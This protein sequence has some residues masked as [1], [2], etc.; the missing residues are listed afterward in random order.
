MITEGFALLLSETLV[1]LA[2]A[3]HSV[4]PCGAAGLEISRLTRLRLLTP[5][6]SHTRDLSDIRARAR[7]RQRRGRRRTWIGALA[8]DT[9][10]DGYHERQLA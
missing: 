7:F 3:A 9:W 1:V 5:T 6:Y 8:V 4:E 10:R 2:L